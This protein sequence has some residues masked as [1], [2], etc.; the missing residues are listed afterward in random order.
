[1]IHEEGAR[2]EERELLQRA[3]ARRGDF[4]LPKH[5][6][7]MSFNVA[8][9]ALIASVLTCR[10]YSVTASIIKNRLGVRGTIGVEVAI[11]RW[12]AN[13]LR[14]RTQTQCILVSC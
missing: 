6:S 9:C 7:S 2:E 3:S 5:R 10:G 13:E 8:Q 4:V 11:Q 12:R 1:M 14:E